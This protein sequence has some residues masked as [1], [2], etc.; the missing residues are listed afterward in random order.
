MSKEDLI[1]VIESRI[2]TIEGLLDD[3]EDNLVK[4]ET[5]RD[6]LVRVED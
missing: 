3:L 4:V 2:D 1:A 6:S 5:F